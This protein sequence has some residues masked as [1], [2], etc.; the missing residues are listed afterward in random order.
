MYPITHFT[1]PV[2]LLIFLF[3]VDRKLVFLLAPLTIL[4]DF[5]IFTTFHRLLF[6][7][8]FV[9]ILS[10]FLSFF[11]LRTVFKIEKKKFLLVGLF[12]FFSHLLLDF[13]GYGVSFFYPLDNHLYGFDYREKRIVVNE[14]S[15]KFEIIFPIE[16]IPKKEVAIIIILQLIFW[17]DSIGE[18]YRQKSIKQ[19]W[20]RS[21]VKNLMKKQ[22]HS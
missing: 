12:L 21:L 15:K 17:Y 8:I 1:V 19:K 9:G 18:F 20:L 10:V 6:H 22:V 7:N 13:N 2:I 3:N 16:Q 5:D 14:F 11:V 4:P